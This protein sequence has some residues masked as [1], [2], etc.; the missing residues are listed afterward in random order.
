M[1]DGVEIGVMPLQVAKCQGSTDHQK[2]GEKDGM[3]SSLKSPERINPA[4]SLI[5]YFRPPKLKENT[6]LLFQAFQLVPTVIWRS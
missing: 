6:F 5:S 3:V 4:N 2:P 1:E